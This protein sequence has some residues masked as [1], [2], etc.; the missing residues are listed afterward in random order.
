MKKQ[1]IGRTLIGISIIHIVLGLIEYHSILALL[2]REG[3]FNTIDQQWDR[4]TAFWFLNTG[5]SLLLLGCIINWAEKN[6]SRLPVFIGW[7][8][9]C[10]TILAVIIMPAPGFWLIFIPAIG[11][12]KRTNG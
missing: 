5:F 4:N 6:N 12:I 7:G 2:V 9:L 8:L 1:W 3:L 11:L 10:M